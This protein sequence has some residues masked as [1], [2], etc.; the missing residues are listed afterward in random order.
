MKQYYFLIGIPRTGNTLLSSIL[1]QNPDLKVSANSFLDDHLYQTAMLSHTDKYQNFPDDNSLMNLMYGIFDSYYRD[2]NVKYIIDRGNWGTPINLNLLQKVFDNDIKIICTVRDIVEIIASFI[3]VSP[4][5]WRKELEKEIQSN[6]RYNKSYKSELE[7]LCEVIMRPKSQIET[8]LFGLNNLFY[9]HRDILHIVE[10]ND[11]VD[12]TEQTIREI[13]DFLNIE[14]YP[15]KF[16][17]INQFE[18]NGVKYD[19]SIWGSDLHKLNKKIKHS[20]YKVEDILTS[21]LIS[22]YSNME[23]W[24]N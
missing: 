21:E 17:Y 4:D 5:R 19:D 2:W 24:R 6:L 16:N 14:Y 18:V 13:Y 1:N 15:H 12:N 9:N 10:Y 20:N 7:L 23:F 22:K 8:A 3:K 11:L